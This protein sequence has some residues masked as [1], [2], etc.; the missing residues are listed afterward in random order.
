MKIPTAILRTLGLSFLLST[1]V[2]FSSNIKTDTNTLIGTYSTIAEA[3]YA[4]AIK[5][6]ENLQ[7]AIADLAKHPTEENL[8]KAKKAWLNARESYGTSEILRL[9]G[10]PIDA[11]EGWVADAYGSLEAQMNAWPLDEN[12]IDYT[13]DANGKRTSGNI[14]DSKGDFDP[15]GEESTVINVDSISVEN[16]TALN[17][18][19]G[20]ANVATGYHAIEFLLWGQDQDYANFMKDSIT[21]GAMR[22]GERPLSDFS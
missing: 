20:D 3:N 5:D 8:D 1:T 21:H 16:L 17:E 9:S 12:M 15:G 6:A 2:C 18:N 4:D 11:E 22:A 10:G 14:I 19:G 13:I 7:K